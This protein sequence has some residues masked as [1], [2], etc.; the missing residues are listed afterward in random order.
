VNDLQTALIGAGAAAVAVV[1]GYNKWQERQQ[2]KLAE[3][4]FKGEQTDALMDGQQADFA[5]DYSETDDDSPTWEEPGLP[6]DETGEPPLPGQYA[7]EIVDCIVRIEFAEPVAASDLWAA[8]SRWA[9]YIRKP[10][11]WLGFDDEANAWQLMSACDTGSYKT[12]CVSLQLADR[13]GPVSDAE[14]SS[15]L[16]GVWELVGQY[17]GVASMPKHDEVMTATRKLDDFC[18][19]VDLQLSVKVVCASELMTGLC[20]RQLAEAAGLSLQDDG[21]FHAIAANGLTYFT[22]ASIG[23]V[24]FQAAS[25]DSLMTHG[26][27]LSMDVPRVPDGPAAFDALMGLADSLTEAVSGALVDSQGNPLTAEMIAG[28]RDKIAQIQDLL[29]QHRIVAGSKRALRLFS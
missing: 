11:S 26:V 19:G 17:A 12:V 9:G 24:P 14:L 20:V 15:F 7:D 25:L 28:I 6:E 23:S 16:D 21:A 13:Q 8:Q 10:M 4:L 1:W 5:D 3:K 2:K 29:A 22:V 27:V 18:A